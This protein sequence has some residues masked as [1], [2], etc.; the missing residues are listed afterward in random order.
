MK[1]VL[2]GTLILSLSIASLTLNSCIKKTKEGKDIT[3]ENIKVNKSTNIETGPNSPQCKVNIQLLY[4]TNA[5]GIIGKRINSAIIDKLFAMQKLSAQN[6]VDSFTNKYLDDYK[7]NYGPFYK[8]DKSNPE[9]KKTYQFFYNLSSETNKG[10]NGI[11]VYLIKENFYEG[12]AHGITQTIVINFDKNT[13]K[14]INIS[15]VFVPGYENAL[16]GL[17][18]D[19]L[20]KKTDTKN[21]DELK[22]K[23]Y[24]VSED[25][26]AP[27]NFIIGDDA[28]TF[29]YNPYEIAPYSIGKIEIKLEYSDL[30]KILNKNFK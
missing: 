26:Y 27:E 15:D 12:G 8:E 21:V 2:F 28:I 7:T 20:L 3:F 18:L 29:I 14:V 5:D 16:N 6:A 23:G 9:K 24:L 30:S 11:V 4:A 25:I 13:G 17:L 19:A 10:K 22:S 1:K